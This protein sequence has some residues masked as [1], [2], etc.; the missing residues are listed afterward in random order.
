LDNTPDG[1]MSGQTQATVQRILDSAEVKG[2]RVTIRVTGAN[3]DLRE[4]GTRNFDIDKWKAAFDNMSGV[5]ANEYV[6]SGTLIA[7]FAIDEPFSDFDNMT[8]AT[9]EEICQYQKSQPGWEQVPCFIREL[10][11]RLYDK[12]P[13]GGAYQYV[14][15]GWAQIADHHYVPA[16]KYDGSMLAYFEDNLAKGDSFGPGLMYG[17]NLIDGGREVPGCAKP[18][19]P[20]HHNCAMSAAEIRA[21]ADT[22]AILGNGRGCGV[23][24]WWI[25]PTAGPSRKYFFT[26]GIQS[27]LEYLNGKVGTLSP[28]PCT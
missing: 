7:H 28:G 14:D 9:L 8:G 10:N 19:D 15:A 21:V 4:T 12:R 1:V 11:T 13:Q 24:G 20:N 3:P 2:A 5:D 17:F 18:S 16:L 26:A 27:A 23:N 6:A 25:D 22:L